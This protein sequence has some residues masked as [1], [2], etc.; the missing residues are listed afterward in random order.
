MKTAFLT[1]SRFRN[2]TN[3][4]H[5]PER[6]AR[7]DAI[8]EAL[9]RNGLWDALWKPEFAAAQDEHLLLCHTLQLVERIQ[10][11]AAAGGGSIDP[12]TAV[13]PASFEVARLAVGAAVRA[14]DAVL[15]GECD[16]AFVAVR[17]P[18]HHA[19]TNR[20]MGFCLFNN[21]ACAAR[22]AQRQHGLERVAILDW[23]VH[24]GNGTQEI[25][26]EDPSAFF[27]SVH[28]APLFPYQGWRE[29]RGRGAAIGTTMNVPLS[30]GQGDDEYAQVWELLAEPV[31]EFAPQ[32]I[33]ISA[34]FDAHARDPLG[35]MRVSAAGFRHL[36]QQTK[37]WAEQLCD[38]RIVCVLEGGYD[39]D[40]LS[41][42]VAAT[43][44][45]LMSG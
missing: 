30:A 35:G 14:V 7:L 24:H 18:G 6:P 21:I 19:E 3:G 33:F 31:Q 28:Q 26:Y 43:L 2:H 27:F 36:M 10:R 1:D 9:Q 34:G 23:D 17:P 32:M 8:D 38:G 13:S 15:G 37:T 12:D 45:E 29:E 11:M 22:Y 44:A 25:F 5:H 39:L 16:N 41:E 40:G 4:P 20:A 42:S